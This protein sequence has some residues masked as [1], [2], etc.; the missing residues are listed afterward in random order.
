MTDTARAHFGVDVGGT[1]TD[2]SVALPGGVEILHKVPSTPDAPD[3]AIIQGLHDLLAD[4]R[5][6]PGA[7]ARLAHG[8][9]VG[10]NALIQRRVGTV[11]MVTTRG[12][13]DLLEIGRQTRPRVYDIHEDHPRPLVPRHLRMEV[14]ERMRADGT[15]HHPLD[16][17]EVRAA[18]RRLA[19][20]RVD[21]IAVCLLHAHAHPAH[22]R[23]AA[24]IL[25]AMLPAMLVIAS[26]EVH[27]EFR[28]YER[29]S[30]TVLNGALLTVMHAYLDR[31]ERDV[32]ALGITCAPTISQ[33]AGGLMSIGMARRF[34]VRSALSGPAAGAI[35]AAH[36]AARAGFPAVI[37][38]DVGGTSA[39][40]A[41]LSNGEPALV[42]SRTLAGFPLRLPALDVNSVGA[43]GGSIAWIDRDGLMKVGP[44]SAG[45]VP[46][47]ACYDRGGTA[48]T[49]TDAQVLLGRLDAASLLDGRMTIR[50]DLAEA[51]VARLAGTLDLG[52]EETA[53]GIVRLACATMVKAMR[54]I[55][56]ERGHDPT[57]S[58]LF[59]FG[60]AGPLH[61]TG[62]ARDLGIARIVVPPHPGI[63]CAEGLLNSDLATDLVQPARLRMDGRAPAA[64]AEV[65]A[66]LLAR[67]EAWFIGEQVGQGAERQRWSADLRYHGQNFELS[68]PL[69]PAPLDAA[70]LAALIARFHAEHDRAYGFAQPAEP[71]ELVNI[72]LQL[73]GILEK[74]TLQELAP[75]A[76]GHPVATRRVCFGPDEWHATPVYRRDTLAPGQTLAGPAIIEQMD[77]TTPIFPG[78]GCTV[79]RWGNLLITLGDA[80]P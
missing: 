16:E 41:M 26:H 5:L 80:A 2:F 72:R 70:G 33:S 34:P 56:V 27:P 58:A 46:G 65:R 9:T 39:D 36:R 40:V 44:H 28:E 76:P 60:G 4:P 78:D 71:V 50:R 25:R 79:D 77:C 19:A 42:H 38:L 66:A 3:R 29:F 15:V 13:R 62:T 49:V 23:R 30:T 12:F 10:T 74:P 54:S 35:G 21:C 17:D 24:E 69:D 63:L 53:L 75:A 48:A 57:G 45:A 6:S 67:A 47:P 61:A 18:G 32:A 7:V 43:G 31:L 73:A 55:S 22:E 37:T 11:G 68:L 59:A 52:V 1:F 14:T 51:A 8:S 64:I 20:A